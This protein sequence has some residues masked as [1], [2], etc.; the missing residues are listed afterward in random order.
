M[1]R[2]P[3]I[4]IKPKVVVDSYEEQG[5]NIL[6]DCYIPGTEEELD[7]TVTH[8]E[9]YDFMTGDRKKVWV[10]IDAETCE[11]VTF[12]EWLATASKRE[13]MTASEDLINKREK[14]SGV[15]EIPDLFATLGNILNPSLSKTA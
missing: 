14:R 4:I 7:F 11:P 5:A 8:Q 13:I 12:I 9:L 3:L 1:Q 15:A 6:C 10:S 2:K